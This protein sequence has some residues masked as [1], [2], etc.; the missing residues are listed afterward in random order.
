[1][2]MFLLILLIGIFIFYLV[3]FLYLYMA[4]SSQQYFIAELS[5]LV[6]RTFREFYKGEDIEPVVVN[7]SVDLVWKGEVQGIFNEDYKQGFITI[8]TNDSIAN[9]PINDLKEADIIAGKI[10]HVVYEY[11]KERDGE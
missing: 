9:S 7:N 11:I 10:A 3:C 2:D 8:L 1:M 6:S 5:A 4:L